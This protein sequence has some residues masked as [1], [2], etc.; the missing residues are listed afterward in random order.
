MKAASGTI[1]SATGLVS[2]TVGKTLDVANDAVG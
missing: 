2:D 1:S